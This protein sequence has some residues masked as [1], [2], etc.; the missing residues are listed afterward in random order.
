MQELISINIVL[1]GYLAWHI[2]FVTYMF[3]EAAGLFRSTG[4]D[5]SLQGPIVCVKDLWRTQMDVIDHF[6]ERAK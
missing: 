1:D 6:G 5:L 4:A 2:R 3:C